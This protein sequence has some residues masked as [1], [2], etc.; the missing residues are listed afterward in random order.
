MR[1]NLKNKVRVRELER[2][3]VIR[4]KEFKPIFGPLHSK[5]IRFKNKYTLKKPDENKYTLKKPDAFDFS[6]KSKLFP[7]LKNYRD[8]IKLP[9]LINGV[10]NNW[11]D[12]MEK[13]VF[14][15]TG[16]FNDQTPLF[17]FDKRFDNVDDLLENILSW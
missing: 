13:N 7:K 11:N 3:F 4:S 2:H 6:C 9:T 15:Y 5:K 8:S 10:S 17:S 12:N 16:D 14:S 1:E